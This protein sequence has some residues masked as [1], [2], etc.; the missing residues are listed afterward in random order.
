MSEQLSSPTMRHLIACV[1]LAFLL[2]GCGG[3]GVEDD[4]EKSG[5]ELRKIAAN[6]S[7]AELKAKMDEIEKYGKEFEEKSKGVEEPTK[8][9]IEKASKLMEIT[10]IYGGEL[11]K[12]GDK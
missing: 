1:S 9:D 3:G 6:M 11:F 4:L 5:D 7:T 12:R 10:G 2:A 8:A